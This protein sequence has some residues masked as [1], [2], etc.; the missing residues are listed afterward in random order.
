MLRSNCKAVKTAIRKEIED[1]FKV[2]LDGYDDVPERLQ[3]KARFYI[4][5][6][7]DELSYTVWFHRDDLGCN[8]YHLSDNGRIQHDLNSGTWECGTYE[9]W[10]MVKQWLEQTDEEAE[11]YSYEKG[12]EMWKH[13]VA[14]EVEA[15][16]RMK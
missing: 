4:S 12:D 13:L 5:L 2:R 9:R 6:L 1:T 7:R 15:L 10:A 11:R 8:P 3:D 14:R 16:A